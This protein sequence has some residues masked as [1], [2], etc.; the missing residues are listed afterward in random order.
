M[1]RIAVRLAPVVVSLTTGACFATRSDVRILQQDVANVRAS[2]AHADSARAAQIAQLATTL[3]LVTDSIRASSERLARLQANA[4]GDLRSIQEQLVQIQELTGQSQN[5][6]NELR[7]QMEERNAQM[8]AAA[9]TA[10]PIP[11]DTTQPAAATPPAGPPSPGPAT[12]YKLA[13]DQLSRGSHST[14]R[15]GFQDLLS[16]FP[17]SDLAPDAQ[18]WIGETYLAEGNSGAADSVFNLVVTTY[19]RAS[20]AASALYKHGLYL[21]KAKRASEARQVFQSVI[22]KYPRSD[23]ADL[24]RDQL[25]QRDD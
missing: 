3:G 1:N 13:Y 22:D 6:L 17:T 23:E 5:K 20:R 12:L 21:Q 11:G 24:A 15:T 16:K 8:P 7:A 2:A 9:P 18:Y 10:T 4:A 14:A 19:P 25:R